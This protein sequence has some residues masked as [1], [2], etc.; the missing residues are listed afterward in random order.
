MQNVSTNRHATR[1]GVFQL[2]LMVSI[3]ALLLV[4]FGFVPARGD[5]VDAG[6]VLVDVNTES[7]VVGSTPA[8]LPNTGAIA[9][10]F[11]LVNQVGQPNPETVEITDGGGVTLKGI[12]L[13]REQPFQNVYQGP[14]TSISTSSAVASRRD[15]KMIRTATGSI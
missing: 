3:S 9:G 8:T 6:S 13:N 7:L 14:V 10:D 12:H 15:R 5:L 11:N 4:A 1:S 2:R